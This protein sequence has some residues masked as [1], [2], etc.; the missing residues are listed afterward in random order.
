MM[1]RGSV[2]MEFIMVAPLVTILISMLLQF[3]QI[4]I[5]RAI[6]AYAAYSACRSVL[7]ANAAEADDVAQKAA[8]LA[9]SW[10]CLAGLPST[11]SA[12]A[13][14]TSETV[15]LG[16]FHDRDDIDDSVTVDHDDGSPLS[17][18]IRIP[19]WGTIPGSDSASVRVEAEVLSRGGAAD[20]NVAMVKVKF[21][22]PLLLPLAGRMIS[23]F[24]KQSEDSPGSGD[25]DPHDYGS[26]ELA[27]GNNRAWSGQEAVMYGNGDLGI[28]GG[29]EDVK[30]AQD[31][32]FPAIT[33]TDTCVLP[34]RYSAVNLRSGYP[35]GVDLP[36]G[37][38][39]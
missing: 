39:L 15:V 12:S 38:G 29:E 5:A 20:G 3:S 25:L 31:G 10:M 1:R 19:G 28:R 6:T 21:K 4:W 30:F 27:A 36:K 7:S 22:F 26:H 34:M 37:G 23:Y 24:V 32:C 2:L 8:E 13:G 16:R 18:E 33:L 9:C 11:V 17:G 35:E 14:G